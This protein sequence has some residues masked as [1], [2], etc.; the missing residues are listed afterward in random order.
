MTAVLDRPAELSALAGVALQDG[1]PV[2]LVPDAKG[3]PRPY[4]VR[5]VE[6][7]AWELTAGHKRYVVSVGYPTGHGCTCP[8]WQ[9]GREGAC[10]HTRAVAA[11]LALADVFQTADSQPTGSNTMTTEMAKTSVP[12]SEGAMEKLLVQGDLK[13]LKE[14]ERL[15]YYRAVCDSLGLNPLTQPFAYITLSGKLTLY[16][17]KDATEQLRRNHKVSVKIVAREETAGVYVVTAQA[18]LPDGRVDESIGAVSLEG[19]KGEARAN[20]IMR[21]ETKSKRRVTLSICGLGLLDETEVETI[22]DAT[23]HAPP[24][25]KGNGS[26]KLTPANYLDRLH[27]K[28]TELT[29]EGVIE[30]GELVAHVTNEAMR[31]GL[32][33]EP[34]EWPLE[35]WRQV[36]PLIHAFETAARSRTEA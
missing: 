9:F 23:P 30:A 20:G 29:A 36:A 32:P 21:A 5:A 14:G 12:V 26:K 2:L 1:R 4:A 3:V 34:G 11:L 22:P 31:Q 8:A 25:A 28:D 33:E 17:R 19:L 7:G 6:P 35:W 18:T 16:A 13:G 10:K 15:Q 27:Q 24:P